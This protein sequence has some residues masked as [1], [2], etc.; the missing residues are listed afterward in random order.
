M[1]LLPENGAENTSAEMLARVRRPAEPQ[2]EPAFRT[3]GHFRR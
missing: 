1:A 2:N 3:P